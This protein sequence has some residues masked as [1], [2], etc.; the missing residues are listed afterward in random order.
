MAML[1]GRGI[2]AVKE[3][4]LR[5][6]L[7]LHRDTRRPPSRG[8]ALAPLLLH[9]PTGR[10]RHGPGTRPENAPPLRAWRWRYGLFRLQQ[11]DG[12]LYQPNVRATSS[13]P[14][15]AAPQ[16]RCMATNRLRDDRA[17]GSRGRRRRLPLLAPR[18]GRTP[19]SRRPSTSLKKCRRD[20]DGKLINRHAITDVEFSDP[21]DLE[22]HGEARRH[23]R[24]LSADHVPRRPSG[25]R[26]L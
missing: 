7:R 8:G 12:W 23:R 19:P 10:P 6:L 1:N 22:R 9:E 20:G 16:T 4:G 14:T 17:R 25:T 3:M 13:F 15:P 26:W 11:D 18:P 2:T 5:R 21:Q 24:D